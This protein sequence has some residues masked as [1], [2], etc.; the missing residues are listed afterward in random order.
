MPHDYGLEG[1]KRLLPTHRHHS[2]RQLR[3]FEDL[4]VLRILRESGKLRE[5][6]PHSA[7]LRVSGGKKIS[8]GF[9]G[10]TWI[11]GK[12]IPYS[13]KV[14]TLP[15]PTSRSASGPWKLKCQT[16]GFR[17]I[18]FQGSIPGIGASITT[19]LST[20]SGYVAA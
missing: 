14:D 9:V 6:G 17:R 15:A 19:N 2:H 20:L 4:V 5:P 13:V 8:G 12:V 11:A 16:P 10:P 18:S 1:A 3:L 7:R